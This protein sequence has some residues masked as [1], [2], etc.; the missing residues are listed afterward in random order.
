METPSLY[1]MLAREFGPRHWWPVTERGEK[2][3]SYKRRSR[4]SARQKF[5]VCVGAILTQNTAWK[6]AERA[7]ENLLNAGILSVQGI[8]STPGKRLASL[9]KPSGYFNQKSL[10]IKRFAAHVRK[11]Y[12]GNLEKMLSKPAAQLRQELLSL[13]GIGEETADSIMLYA[14][15]RPVFV[16]DAYTKRIAE[17]VFGKEFRSY[18]ELQQFFWEGMPR[19]VPKYGEFH[20]LLV[21]LG[22]NFCTKKPQC[23]KCPINKNC[24]YYKE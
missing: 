9:I 4:L 12:A 20:A 15:G 21:E 6:N 17:R 18:A 14:A 1:R 5:E 7:I 3:P 19:S 13:H 10:R 8:S 24:C 11:E 22:K 2:K 16:V 23:G